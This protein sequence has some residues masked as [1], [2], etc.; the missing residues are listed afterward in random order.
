MVE[1]I[2]KEDIDFKIIQEII[3]NSII[4]RLKLIGNKLNNLL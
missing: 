3:N 2:G 4:N 1:K